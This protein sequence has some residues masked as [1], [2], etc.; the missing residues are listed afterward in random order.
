MTF[1]GTLLLALNAV[2]LAFVFLSHDDP[3][4]ATRSKLR[5]PP[6]ASVR[7]RARYPRQAGIGGF[8][9]HLCRNFYSKRPKGVKCPFCPNMLAAS[10]LN[11]VNRGGQINQ[12]QN[13]RGRPLLAP[14][15]ESDPGTHENPCHVQGCEGG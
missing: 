10:G 2:G 7:T 14:Y 6:V 9:A 13:P 8:D 12:P 11:L 5:E 4:I 3:P 15:R 1:E